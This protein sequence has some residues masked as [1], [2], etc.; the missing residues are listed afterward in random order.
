MYQVKKET[1]VAEYPA[2]P[3]EEQL[4]DVLVCFTCFE[5][6]DENRIEDILIKYIDNI[7]TDTSRIGTKRVLI[8][9]YAHLSKQL[10]SARLAKDFLK[11]LQEKLLAEGFE[12]HRSPFGWYKNFTL[13]NIGHPLAESYRE[14]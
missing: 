2:N 11:I 12:A 10:G 14:Y 13:T 5:K 4:K 8:H 3:E 9:P 1:P 7:K 6:H